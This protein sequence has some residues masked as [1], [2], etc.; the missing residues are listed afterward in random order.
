MDIFQAIAAFFLSFLPLARNPGPTGRRCTGLLLASLLAWAGATSVQAAGYTPSITTAY[1]QL[2][3][4]V[5][6]PQV[7]W[8][9]GNG[10]GLPSAY[11]SCDDCASKIMPIGF[12]F[13]FG[14]VA[15]TNWS[16]SSNGVIFFETA[17]VGG[18]STATAQGTSTYTPAALPTNAFGTLGRPAL[19]PFWADL[20]K[21]ASKLNVLANNDP[22]QPANASFFQYEVKNVS[23]AQVLVIQLK[24][25][26]YFAAPASPVNMQIQLWSTGQIV[27]SYGTLQVLASN[28]L[29]RIGLQYPGGGCNTLANIQSVSLSNQSY[30]YTWDSAAATCPAAPTIN[31]YEI[32]KSDT[33]TLC[34]DPVTVLACSVATAP[35]PAA[36]VVST[37]IINAAINVSGVG[38]TTV[39]KSPPSFNIQPSAPL[40]TVTLTWPSGSAGSATLTVQAAFSATGALGCTN[41]AG[42]AVSANCNVA[43]SNTACVAPPHHFQIQGS[44]NG[45]TCAA[46]TLTIKAWADAGQTTPYTAALATGTLT[47]SGNSASIPNLGA[48]SIPAGSSSV[49]ITPITFLAAGSTTFTTTSAPAL[50]G[51]TTCDF[52]G[53]TSCTW[54]ASSAS[55]V[56]DFNCTETST[57][58]VPAD[59]NA[60]TGRLYTKVAGTAFSFDVMARASGGAVSS[61]YASDADKTVT[62]ELVDSTT[63]A[64]CAAYPALS[65][66]VASQTLTF[67]KANQPTQQGRQSISFTVPNAYKNVRCRATDSTG[68][69]GCSLDNFAIRP[70]AAT[71]VTSPAMATPP[72]ATSA[73]PIKAGAAFTLR[74]TTTA[75]SNYSPSLTQDATK[76]T[77]QNTT[78]VTSQQTGGTVGALAPTALVSNAAAVNASYGEVGY[79]YLAAGAFYDAAAIA[80]TAADSSP[81]DCVASSFS[82]TP[83]NGKVGCSIG[84]AAAALGRFVPDHFETAIVAVTTAP[85]TPLGCPGSLICPVNTTPSASGFVYANQPFTLQV[86]AKNATGGTTANYRDS[87]AKA[88]TLSAWNAVGG[89][90]ANPGSGALAGSAVANT[91]FANGVA[92][93]STASY[94]TT[95]S[96]LLAPTNVYFRAAEATGGDGVTSLQ[97]TSV[98]AGLKIASGRLRIANAYGSEK[99]PLLLPITAQYFDGTGWPTSNTDSTTTFNSALAPD[100]ALAVTKVSGQANC[101]SVKAAA[102]G[103]LASGVRTVSLLAQGAC[104]Y[105]VSLTGMPVYLP[106][107]PAV[108]GKVTFG[109]FKSPLIYRRENY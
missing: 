95:L 96:T 85:T 98:E 40:Q 75:G 55:C 63:A 42:T 36:S 27:Y 102:S 101:I 84:T 53:S 99:L 43:V 97:T 82:D 65:P 79:A 8:A 90:S 77:A 69:K 13:T 17:A 1:P 58:A 91:V 78:N 20:I 94:G 100:G 15:Y 10:T 56:A 48:F 33:A 57:P 32:R 109:V 19:M 107:S 45:S 92:A 80:Y 83:V 24:N 7:V 35:C 49:N 31:H 41:V 108:G 3:I 89:S 26:G 103:A 59:S 105:N 73:N 6:A 87:F 37:Q 66:A 72:S 54:V 67:T 18:N 88:T 16:M 14:G 61:A 64:A 51:A 47:Q 28:A 22:T 38:A 21:N 106:I 52:G 60:A 81:G 71:L 68:V 86:T 23:G 93:I 50:A 4:S 5:S 9:A 70:P 25:V 2:A 104:G 11:V 39:N 29:L 44:A 30:L 34:P 74:A 46:N 62:V 76:L 12:S